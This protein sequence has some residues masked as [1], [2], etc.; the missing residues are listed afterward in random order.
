MDGNEEP[1][2]CKLKEKKRVSQTTHSFSFSPFFLFLWLK[3]LLMILC[4]SKWLFGSGKEVGKSERKADSKSLF[5]GCGCGGVEVVV[6]GR[7]WFGDGIGIGIGVAV[8]WWSTPLLLWYSSWCRK[9][10]KKKL[11]RRAIPKQ[12]V[13]RWS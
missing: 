2:L 7:V 3:K 8:W 11:L 12:T 4:M 13:G 5:L 1:M 9:K 10:A 6:S